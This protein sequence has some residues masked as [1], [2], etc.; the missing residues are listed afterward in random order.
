MSVALETAA[1]SERQGPGARRIDPEFFPALRPL[2]GRLACT[3]GFDIRLAE[4]A[5]H[6]RVVST[7]LRRR[8]DWRGYNT[9][10][11]SL[12]PDDPNRLT[13]AAWQ[14]DELAATVS[15]RRDGADGLQN[16]ALYATELAGLRRPDRVLC[17]VS[18]LAVDPDFS[19]RDLLI[20]L[21]QSVVRYAREV[22]K[23]SDFVIGV[24][25]RHVGYYQRRFGFR[26]LGGVQRCQRVNAPVVLLHCAFDD[27]DL[28]AGW[29]AAI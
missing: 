17:E 12:R 4:T 6:H 15:V 14:F 13:V 23:G 24:N 20:A 18:R 21:F 25:P 3:R 29:L 1:L 26:Q 7:L 2:C 10:S 9:E 11:I 28:P 16:D 5:D 27:S 19:C 8:Y 22:F